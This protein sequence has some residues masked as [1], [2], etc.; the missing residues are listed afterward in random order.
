MADSSVIAGVMAA[1]GFEAMADAGLVEQVRR[2]EPLAFCAVMRRYNQ[3][4]F[5]VARA[6]MADDAEAEDVVQESYARAFAAIGGFRGEAGLGTWLTRIVINESRGRLR[7]RRPQVDLDQVERSQEAGALILGFPGGKIVD[8]PEADAARAEVRR[9]LE[10]A[11]DDLPEP[12][13]LVFTLRD[14]EGRPVEEV[15]GLLDIRAETVRTRL[16]RARRQ[17]RAALDATLADA[18]RGSFPFLG[19]RCDRLVDAVM[20]RL[21]AERGW[22]Q[23]D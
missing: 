17:L 7:R 9:L 1:G 13:R 8:D 5:R 3:P 12:F 20:R 11:V 2:G 19:T 18:L 14:I 21:C 15:A 10:R 6:I 22:P 16:H 23:P 4:L